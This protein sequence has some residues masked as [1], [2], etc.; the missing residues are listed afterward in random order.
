MP[1]KTALSTC[2]IHALNQI[3]EENGLAALLQFVGRKVA[4]EAADTPW[5][6]ETRER[7]SRLAK[8]VDAAES[9]FGGK[10]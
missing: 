7:L 1:R 2:E 6:V 5:G 8:E 4:H 9:R 10:L 3:A